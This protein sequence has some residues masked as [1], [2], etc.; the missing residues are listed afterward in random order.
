MLNSNGTYT[1]YSAFKT[2]DDEVF[3]LPTSNSG[4][5]VLHLSF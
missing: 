1:D 3:K 4:V 5:A 2:A